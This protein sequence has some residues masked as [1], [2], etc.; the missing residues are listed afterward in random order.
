MKGAVCFMAKRREAS[1]EYADMSEH[2][3]ISS[4]IFDVIKEDEENLPK[5]ILVS[6]GNSVIDMITGGGFRTGTIA[7]LT[8]ASQSGKSTLAAQIT[9]NASKVFTNPYAY[10]NDS[11]QTM[12]NERL[13]S[14]GCPVDNERFFA[15]HI[16][17]SLEKFFAA[18]FKFGAIKEQF[19]TT[20]VPMIVTGD[21]LD[22]MPSE[23]EIE[24]DTPDRAVGLRAKILKFY[25]RKSLRMI[26]QYNILL[27]FVAHITK[28]LRMDPYESYTPQLPTLGD[29]NIS[30]GQAVQFFP[31]TTL[32]MRPRMTKANEKDLLEIGCSSSSY[33]VDV[34]TLKCKNVPLK[35]TGTVVFEPNIGFLETETRIVNMFDDDWLPGANKK[36]L[37]NCPDQKFYMKELRDLLRDPSFNAQFDVAWQMYLDWKYGST[38]S[39]MN[40]LSVD[41]GDAAGALEMLNDDAQVRVID[42]MADAG[43]STSTATFPTPQP[44]AAPVMPQITNT[45]IPQTSLDDMFGPKTMPVYREES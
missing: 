44:M 20:D 4:A 10:Y 17:L 45:G 26:R 39:K 3:A 38:I 2:D 25:F 15:T 8:G 37:P 34:T 28:T 19:K 36:Y 11:E 1:S 31:H 30:G 22:S 23:K 24:V 5:Q 41:V 32:F 7:M 6:T 43:T 27:M 13:A 35:I 14:L 40:A 18:L 21:S 9:G 42:A 33:K 29:L 16:S 12:S